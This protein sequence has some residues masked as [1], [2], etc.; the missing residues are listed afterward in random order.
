LELCWFQDG[1]MIL[2]NSGDSGALPAV[3]HL[4]RL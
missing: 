3:T 2:L 1:H 4:R